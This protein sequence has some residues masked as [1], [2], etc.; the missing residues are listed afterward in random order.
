MFKI[1]QERN[2]LPS[3]S[4]L[5][6]PKNLTSVKKKCIK[7]RN[8]TVI[9]TILL[10]YFTTAQAESKTTLYASSKLLQC[11][12]YYPPFADKKTEARR[13]THGPGYTARK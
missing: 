10:E 1:N 11:K 2:D 6:Y 4:Q 7:M 9:K 3:L 13:V 8:F 5:V 12:Y